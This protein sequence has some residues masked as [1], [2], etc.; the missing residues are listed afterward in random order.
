MYLN[1]LMTNAPH[2]KDLQC[3][4]IDCFLYDGQHLS[5]KQLKNIMKKIYESHFLSYVSPYH[6][7]LPHLE[8]KMKQVE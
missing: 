3:K 4:S 7:I 1:P 8:L 5:F 6:L 2:Q